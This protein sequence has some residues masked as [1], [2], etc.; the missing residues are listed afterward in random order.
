MVSDVKDGF[1]NEGRTAGMSLLLQSFSTSGRDPSF[2]PTAASA[3]RVQVER[4]RWECANELKKASCDPHYQH[5]ALGKTK[6]RYTVVSAFCAV[7][8]CAEGNAHT[9]ICFKHGALLLQTHYFPILLYTA[10]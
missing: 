7:H 6:N 10:F 8:C 3:A 4:S 2:S 9:H 1:S 5:F